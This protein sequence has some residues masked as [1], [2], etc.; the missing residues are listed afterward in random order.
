[1]QPS[2]WSNFFH[3]LKPAQTVREIKA[4]GFDFSELACE[5]VV[6]PTNRFSAKLAQELRAACDEVGLRTP[7]VHYP[8]CTLNPAVRYKGWDPDMLTE[9]AHPKEDRREF[10]IR[11]AEELLELCPVCGIEVMVVHP[12]GLKGWSSDEERRKIRDLN[13]EAFQRMARTAEKH[14]VI[15][16][17]ENMGSIEGRA[18]FGADFEEL[19]QMVDAVG[20]AHVGICVDTSHANYMRVDIPAA[21]RFAGTRIVATHI[22]DNLGQ[23]DDHLMPYAGS[24]TWPP[25]VEA[26]KS[27]GYQRL[28]NL[29]IPGENR[30]PLEI[31]RLKASYARKLLT[32][33]LGV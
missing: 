19:S 3:L 12:G 6:D 11:C 4:A 9:F 13:I 15:I 29:E 27:I 18:S 22:S 21:I 14:N 23:H 7:Q 33:M 1:M 8:I 20:S 24:I 16:A 30:C 31:L 32:E 26:L 25:I 10:D 17:A 2:L 5:T 28:F